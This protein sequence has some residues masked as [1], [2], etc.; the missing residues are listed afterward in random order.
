MTLRDLIE[1]NVAT[2]IIIPKIQRDYAQGR[3]GKEELRSNFLSDL[4]AVIENTNENAPQ[5]IYD[6][7]YGQ[8]E[9]PAPSHEYTHRFFPVDGQQR[10][11][12][13]FLLTLFIGKRANQ[14]VGF[15]K[16]FS[17]ETRD[18]SQQFC[19][20]LCEIPSSE[21]KDIISFLNDNPRLTGDWKSDPT[22]NS[23]LRMLQDIHL[24]FKNVDD[25]NFNLFWRNVSEKIAFWR[26]YLDDLKTTDDLYIKMNS[27]GKHLSDFENFKAE[28]DQI[29]NASGYVSGEFSKEMDTTWTNLFWSYRDRDNDLVAPDYKNPDSTDFT[30]NGLDDKMLLFF[31]NYLI[32]EGVKNGSLAASVCGEKIS[33][34]ALVKT[35]MD[36]SPNLFQDIEIILKYLDSKKYVDNPDSE[37]YGRL[38]E[39]FS[40]YLT[41]KSEEERF[42]ENPNDKTVKVNMLFQ[43]DTDLFKEMMST[44]KLTVNQKLMI[45]AFLCHI[46]NVSNSNDNDNS[47]TEFEFKNRLR[48]LRNLINNSELHD[49]L[50]H[51]GRMSRTL[52]SVDLLI[53]DG[54]N[55]ISEKAKGEELTGTLKE[56][57]DEFAGPQKDQEMAK[58][59]WMNEASEDDCITLK[60]V[61]N[62]EVV[63]GNLSQL[64]GT[65]GWS[66]TKFDNF[67]KIFHHKVDYDFIEKIMIAFGNYHFEYDKPEGVQYN[68]AGASQRRFRDVIF[69]NSNKKSLETFE[70]LLT[71]NNTSHRALDK[72]CEDII[73]DARKS[74]KY[75]WKYYILNYK[76]MR[77]A[78]TGHYLRVG[79]NY[80]FYMFKASSCYHNDNY[81]HRNVYNDA[82]CML[83]DFD[84]ENNLDRHGGP[85]SIPNVNVTLDIL[86]SRIQLRLND[87]SSFY[88]EIPQKDRVDCIDRVKLGYDIVKRILSMCKSTT[89]DE[90]GNNTLIWRSL[91]NTDL[92][93][94]PDCQII[95]DI[96]IYSEKHEENNSIY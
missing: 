59:L 17:Y 18:S 40:K 26:L 91:T 2:E 96:T 81:I 61:E 48:I 30:N 42:A 21:F 73:Y 11:T 49:D 84:K 35:V 70:S 46:R 94:L 13:I 86:E 8:H 28:I 33:S 95:P 65:S 9:G 16:N 88:V 60:Q 74:E 51:P 93:E 20:L 85:L 56:R 69:V 52:K 82:V 10:L 15:L 66:R 7:V 39:Y 5:R 41:S 50:N 90:N 87:G 27:R 23:M 34:V 47:E 3:E 64:A 57:S 19:K 14:N 63:R 71:K 80:L 89:T 77:W 12:T 92:T 72:Y 75:D 55:A 43:S 31:R 53:T 62:Y 44:P 37:N 45:E 29:A 83:Y 22:I 54:L 78:P 36:E 6:F 4:F 1:G 68:Y 79:V 32:L 58:L 25:S 24:H 38:T 67:R 76:S